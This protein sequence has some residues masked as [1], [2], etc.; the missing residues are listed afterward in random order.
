M[1]KYYWSKYTVG[2]YNTYVQT[3]WYYEGTIA[4]FSHA[5]KGYTLN[6]STGQFSGTGGQ[7]GTNNPPVGSVGYGISGTNIYRLI[8]HDIYTI[9]MESSYSAA[10]S[11]DTAGTLVQSNIIAESGTYPINGKHT[12]GYWYIRGAVAN[13]APKWTAIPNPQVR[14]NA[15]TTLNLANFA[16]DPDGNTLIY[17]TSGTLDQANAK[18]SLSG[19]TLTITGKQIGPASITVVVSDGTTN[20]STTVTVNVVNSEPI[21]TVASPSNKITLYENDTFNIDGTASDTDNG[22]TVT[23]RYQINATTARAIK[24]FLSDGLTL[25]VFSK[26]L[27]FKGGSLYDGT[28]LIAENLADGVAHTLK[29]WATDDQ[30]GSSVIREIPFYV[31]PNRAPLLSVNPPVISGLINSDKFKINGTFEDSDGNI[32]IVSYR[33]NGASSVQIAEGVSGLFEFEV[34][35]GQLNVGTNE[36]IIEAVDSYGAKVS[37]T[38]KLNK[39]TVESPLLRSTVRYKINPPT[40]SA[41]GVLLWIQRDENLDID[42][43]LCMTM[44]DEAESFVPLTVSISAPLDQGS[45][46]VEDEFYHEADS[47]KDNIILQI[48]MERASLEVS[49][50]IYLISG[51]L[52]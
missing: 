17:S 31:V 36:I 37:K 12:D 1:V 30:G 26:A 28:T 22:N 51:V 8:M 47:A 38:V 46:I 45:S 6:T 24:A 50:K 3:D 19:S 44:Q 35:F 34:T 48:D 21:I 18:F 10:R 20:A 39:S 15:T 52:D 33:L 14:K 41:R 23:V 2:K 42:I 11:Q 13:N 40:G 29:V 49:D 5:Y 9:R 27:T 43:A 32:T 7:W 4:S 16:S 25:E